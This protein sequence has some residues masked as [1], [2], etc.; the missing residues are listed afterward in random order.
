MKMFEVKKLHKNKWIFTCR[1]L[2]SKEI[3]LN[4]CGNLFF[5]LETVF[6][7]YVSRLVFLRKS[8]ELIVDTVGN[9]IIKVKV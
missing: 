1:L 7:L 5:L 3:C 4:D 6:H 9:F 8:K 2:F